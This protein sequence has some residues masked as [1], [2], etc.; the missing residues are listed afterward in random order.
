[1]DQVITRECR[2]C[3]E[4][5]PLTEFYIRSSNGKYNRKCKECDNISHS[6]YRKD[7]RERMRIHNRNYTVKKLRG[8]K[9]KGDISEWYDKQLK[10]QGGKCAMTDCF[11]VPET[12]RFGR[13]HIDHNHKT[14]KLRG[15]L[16]RRCNVFLSAIEN[17]LEVFQQY[18][19]E[20]D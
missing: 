4:V 10:L 14:F 20:Y 1:M 11:G 6:V 5:K 17:R 15:L 9:Y 12:E 13:L 7:N 19:A 8:V 16:C 2:K 18:L 3:H